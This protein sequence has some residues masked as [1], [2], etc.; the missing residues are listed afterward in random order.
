M[1]LSPIPT[2]AH[3]SDVIAEA[4]RTMFNGEARVMLP[5]TPGTY[6]P[7]TDTVTGGTPPTVAQDW[8]PAR[9]Q[10][11]GMPLETSDGNGWS[12]KR[13]FRFQ[14]DLLPDDP[15]ITKG[16]YVEYRGGKDPSLARFDYQVLSAVNSSHAALRTVEAM[17]ELGISE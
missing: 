7:I 13:R 16:M 10:H 14:W 8:R 2:A 5:G 15:I 4:A 17:S 3:W 12:T 1:P 11:V 6:D 9:A